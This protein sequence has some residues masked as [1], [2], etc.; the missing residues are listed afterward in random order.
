MGLLKK[1]TKEER[2]AKA[3]AKAM[4]DLLQAE[5]RERDR[6]QREA[7]AVQQRAFVQTL[8]K[9]EHQVKRV[10]EDK[11][12]GLPG[13]G[14]MEQIFNEERQG[15]LGARRCQRGAGHVQEGDLC[16]RLAQRLI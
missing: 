9:W 7:A 6:E 13:S 8:S 11:Q 3:S 5:A 2:A 16:S 12:K 15:R 10:G 4:A 14:R 1:N